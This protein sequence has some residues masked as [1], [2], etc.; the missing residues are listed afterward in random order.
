MPIV[1]MRI[2][3]VIEWALM[4]VWNAETKKYSQD[5]EVSQTISSN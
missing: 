3:R 2:L 1:N 4:G 5:E